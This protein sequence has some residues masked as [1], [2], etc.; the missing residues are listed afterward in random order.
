MMP[1][2][3][4]DIWCHMW[5]HTLSPQPNHQGR[6]KVYIKWTFGLVMADGHLNLPQKECIVWWDLLHLLHL[7]SEEGEAIN[8]D[9]DSQL[10]S[11]A[12]TVKAL[13]FAGIIFC[14]FPNELMWEQLRG[15]WVC[16]IVTIH[17]QTV[18]MVFNFA[19]T[20]RPWNSQNK[21]H[22]KFKAFTVLQRG[23]Y[24]CRNCIFCSI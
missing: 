20:V 7:R 24:M 9:N 13:H 14:G 21:S 22:M 3:S 16:Y 19:E 2:L 17:G 10:Q 5:R 11:G 15:F 4:K 6:H 8:S 1:G 12:G 23:L 18:L